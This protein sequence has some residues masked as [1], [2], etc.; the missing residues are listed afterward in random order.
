MLN[1]FNIGIVLILIGYIIGGC[2]NGVVKETT[3]FI[4]I[5]LVF[6]LSYLLK[7]IVGNILC[8]YLPFFEYG[9]LV[10]LNII[11]YQ[12]VAFAILFIVLSSVYSLLLKISN[13]L[14]KFI[15]ATIILVIPSKILGAIIGFIE[16]WILLFVL[17]VILIL[18]FKNIEQY[19]DSQLANI[20][21]FNTPILSNTVEPFVK[22]ETEIYEVS[23][24]IANKKIKD[25]EANLEAIKIMLK[26]KIVD[27][28]TI[29]KLIEADK[30]DK[31]KNIES[32]LK[33]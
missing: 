12:L 5:I 6:T 28:E 20:I 26:Y 9:G 2:K 19:Q 18:P 30:L 22:G 21:L 27:E 15:N 8:T 4:G 23:N 24:K 32:V 13:G 11:V 33:A 10:S 29:R 25:N 7:G 14:Q 16:G 1:V 17:L 3:T 31:I